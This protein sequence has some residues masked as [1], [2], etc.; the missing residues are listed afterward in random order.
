MQLIVTRENGRSAALPST[1]T[2][3]FESSTRVVSDHGVCTASS[4]AM[5]VSMSD[6][7]LSS[8]YD[9]VSRE[10]GRACPPGDAG[11]LR[12]GERVLQRQVVS[13]P[14]G[15]LVAENHACR[16]CALLSNKI[17]IPDAVRCLEPQFASHEHRNRSALGCGR[18][19][20]IAE[21]AGGLA[22]QAL[23]KVIGYNERRRPEKQCEPETHQPDPTKPPAGFVADPDGS[24]VFAGST[25][26]IVG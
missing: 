3:S 23:P 15:L 22:W 9:A 6:M 4:Y 5:D 21:R 12:P 26:G 1:S 19:S 13:E 18:N 17:A 16:D 24:S 20:Q 11:E 7:T 8:L 2:A 25:V 14:D 10:L